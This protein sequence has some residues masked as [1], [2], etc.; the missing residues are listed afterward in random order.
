MIS[1]IPALHFLIVGSLMFFIGVYGFLTRKNIIAMLLAAELMINAV[2][3]NFAILN[4]FVFPVHLEGYFF[5][6]FIIAVA[7]ADAAVAIAI[8][9]NV[10]R[11]FDTIEV[12]E[13]DDMKY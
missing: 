12:E 8:I 2:A 10:Y 5:S 7:A 3:F 11:N 4:R 13:V 9:I 6:L 1:N